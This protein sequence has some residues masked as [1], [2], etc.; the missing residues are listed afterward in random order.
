MREERLELIV[1]GRCRNA[2]AG[3]CLQP[4]GEP[5]RSQ[6]RTRRSSWRLMRCDG[7]RSRSATYARPRGI[8]CGQSGQG[9]GDHARSSRPVRRHRAVAPAT[10]ELSPGGPTSTCYS[11]RRARSAVSCCTTARCAFR[12]SF[13]SGKQRR[14]PMPSS[15]QQTSRFQNTPEARPFTLTIAP[16]ALSGRR[17]SAPARRRAQQRLAWTS[18]IS[19][20][21]NGG[22]A[23]REP[24]CVPKETMPQNVAVLRWQHPFRF[25]PT[26]GRLGVGNVRHQSR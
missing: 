26:A 1:E 18:G 8:A 7:S 5:R 15:G 19:P 13:S 14:S 16:S 11:A 6:S 3:V 22:L 4:R 12:R 25:C 21:A 10:A 17:E 2:L 24:G 23:R 20:A 9:Q